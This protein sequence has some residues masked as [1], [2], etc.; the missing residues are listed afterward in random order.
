[1]GRLSIRFGTLVVFWNGERR[2]DTVSYTPYLTALKEQYS[3]SSHL[4]HPPV[5]LMFITMGPGQ[6]TRRFFG[7]DDWYLAISDVFLVILNPPRRLGAVFDRR[8]GIEHDVHT[9]FT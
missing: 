8:A 7:I 2:F 6:R 1:M 9:T 5:P 4:T 3:T